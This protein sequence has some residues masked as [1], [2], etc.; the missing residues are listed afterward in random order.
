[1]IDSDLATL[2]NVET[3]RVN[4]QVKRNPERFPPDFMFQLTEEEFKILKSQTGTSS[5]SFKSQLKVKKN[6]L[7]ILDYQKKLDISDDEFRIISDHH[8]FGRVLREG[9][10]NHL[11][12]DQT[13]R[14]F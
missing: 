6:Q 1:M 13:W 2:Y 7:W 10:Q 12:T 8:N 5:W 4:E 14:D 9:L 3:K 11:L